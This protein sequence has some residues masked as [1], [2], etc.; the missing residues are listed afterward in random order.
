MHINR[1]LITSAA[2]C[3][4]IGVGVA[5]RAEAQG[6]GGFGGGR[7]RGGDRGEQAGQEQKDNAAEEMAKR[8]EDMSAAK[9]VMKDLKLTDAAKDSI[10]RIEKTYKE[11]FRT[12]AVATRRQFEDAKAQGSAPDMDAIQKL[13]DDARTLQDQEYSEIRA[14]VPADQQTKFDANVKQHHEDEERQASE[15]RDRMRHGTP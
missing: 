15:H 7:H 13:H 11:R 2:L 8:F 9:P 1:N 4:L 14:L 12:Y 6:G 5:A 3:A 10:G